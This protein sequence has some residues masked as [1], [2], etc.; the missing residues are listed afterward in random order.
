MPSLDE[1]AAD[2]A[3]THLLERIG[4]GAAPSIRVIFL[5]RESVRAALLER[6]T[7]AAA[8][9]CL[10]NVVAA[11]CDK[12]LAIA[13]AVVAAAVDIVDPN[14]EDLR[15]VLR[16]LLS[17]RCSAAVYCRSTEPS[18]LSFVKD[19]VHSKTE[20]QRSRYSRRQ[21]LAAPLVRH[22]GTVGDQDCRRDRRGAAQRA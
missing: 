7:E 20:G 3:A 8:I 14:L 15:A 10:D 4:S 18:L 2:L 21:A 5:A 9:S 17:D 19:S 16:D 11:A 12:G 1:D 6:R 22:A 13:K